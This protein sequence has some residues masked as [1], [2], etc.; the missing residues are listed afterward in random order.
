LHLTLQTLNHANSN[1]GAQAPVKVSAEILGEHGGDRQFSGA[2]TPVGQ[3]CNMVARILDSSNYR[4]LDPAW[5]RD[6][7]ITISF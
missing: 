2:R 5:A 4:A 6:A 1:S 3:G 7:A